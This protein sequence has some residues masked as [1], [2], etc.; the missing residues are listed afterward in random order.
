MTFCS[1]YAMPLEARLRLHRA[2]H[3]WRRL[4]LLGALALA[5]QRR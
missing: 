4:L 2:F 3:A 1:K 5:R